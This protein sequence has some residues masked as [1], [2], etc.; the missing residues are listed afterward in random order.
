MLNT[1]KLKLYVKAVTIKMERGEGEELE[2]ILSAYTKLKAEEKEQIRK[3]I[4]GE[5]G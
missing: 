3:A 5:E 2:T 4:N 1:V